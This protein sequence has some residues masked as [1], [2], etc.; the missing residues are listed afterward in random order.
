MESSACT[1]HI[2]VACCCQSSAHEDERALPFQCCNCCT[3]CPSFCSKWRLIYWSMAISKCTKTFISF[4]SW[5]LSL[6]M[7]REPLIQWPNCILKE[8]YF[9]HAEWMGRKTFSETLHFIT[10]DRYFKITSVQPLLQLE[11]DVIAGVMVMVTAGGG[12]GD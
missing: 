3:V 8:E 9:V 6:L 5:F 4:F 2:I 1:K 7:L 12:S 11:L 10:H